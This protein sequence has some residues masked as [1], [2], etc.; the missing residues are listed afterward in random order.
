MSNSCIPDPLM[1]HDEV[2]SIN[3]TIVDNN[4]NDFFHRD[5]KSEAFPVGQII[6][7][8]AA[9]CYWFR[10]R[11]IIMAINEPTHYKYR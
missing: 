1:T 6:N 2:Q 9:P 5:E 7:L 4:R 10:F 8:D 11:Y 3:Y